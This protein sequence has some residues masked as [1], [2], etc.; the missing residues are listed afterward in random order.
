MEGC[1]SDDI[2]A[3]AALLAAMWWQNNRM[4]LVDMNKVHPRCSCLW[5]VAPCG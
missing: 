2:D 5:H 4:T 1:C 3:R